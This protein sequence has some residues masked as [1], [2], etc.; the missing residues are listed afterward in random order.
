V[1]V[2][3]R[4][5]E[6]EREERREERERE[7][8]GGGRGG[9]EREEERV[10]VCAY[11]YSTHAC[12]RIIRICTMQRE[13]ERAR[14]RES[15]RER[16]R[17]ACWT[18]L[19]FMRARWR[20]RGN[21]IMRSEGQNSV[22]L[23]HLRS[24]HARA[25]SSSHPLIMHTILHIH[26]HIHTSNINT[27]TPSLLDIKIR[28]LGPTH[29]LLG[30]IALKFSYIFRHNTCISYSSYTRIP[31][32]SRERRGKRKEAEHRTAMRTNNSR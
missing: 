19:A 23:K 8:G 10:C 2:C 6:R 22:H 21:A 26:L 15:E 29:T 16:E 1:C 31:D 5:R 27:H 28:A 32:D 12:I 24:F 30:C 17:L 13:K 18:F 14:T 20:E 3:V 25:A 4:E 9:G 11:A 7:R